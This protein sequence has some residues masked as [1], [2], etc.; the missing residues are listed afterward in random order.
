MYRAN[1]G[2]SLP[3]IGTLNEGID[4]ARK[5]AD[6]KDMRIRNVTSEIAGR[7]DTQ[8]FGELGIP[9]VHAFTGVKSPYHTPDDTYDLLDYDGMA[10][11]TE[12]LHVLVSELSVM[13]ELAPS[14]RFARMQQ[15]YGLRFNAGLLA[16][17]GSTNHNYPDEFYKANSVF[18]F[19]TGFFMQMQ[20]GRIF[21]IQPEVLYDYNGSKS[22]QGLYRR[23][24]LTLPLNLQ[25]N[26]AGD[27][28]GMFSVYPIAGGYLRFNLSGRDGGEDLDFNDSLMSREWGVNLGFGIQVMRVQMAFTWRRG[29]TDIPLVQEGTIFDTGRYLTVGY[30]F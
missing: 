23:H 2:L 19:S 6:A 20:V 28:G 14:P 22:P 5:I 8:P 29:L 27:A 13:P 7:T 18:G 26:I 1:N 24:S 30:R 9:A 16:H 25:Y 4:L 21:S 12:Y 11:I 10:L 15:P 17:I 3:G